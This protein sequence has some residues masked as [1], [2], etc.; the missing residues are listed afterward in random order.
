MYH[1]SN[2]D[3]KSKKWTHTNCLLNY[4]SAG[5]CQSCVGVTTFLLRRSIAWRDQALLLVFF[6]S[7]N[8]S[9]ILVKLT[10]TWKK[11][12]SLS[13]WTF[14]KLHLWNMKSTWTA[15]FFVYHPRIIQFYAL[16]TI[17]FQFA[18]LKWRSSKEV[19]SCW[20]FDTK[21][22]ILN[23]KYTVLANHTFDRKNSISASL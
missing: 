22:I 20:T 9:F 2:L 10:S 15:N 17:G 23:T 4:S 8:P 18:C 14:L 19:L 11:R 21:S 5:W 6:Q 13:L 3:S 12:C 7:A 1:L 16:L